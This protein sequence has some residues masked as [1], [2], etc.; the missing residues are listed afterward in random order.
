VRKVAGV[1]RKVIRTTPTTA[2]ENQMVRFPFKVFTICGITQKGYRIFFNEVLALWSL[3]HNMNRTPE[4]YFPRIAVITIAAILTV[5]TSC[6]NDP[7]PEALPQVN[8]ISPTSGPTNTPVIITGTNFSTIL[9]ENKVTFNGKDAVITVATSTQL[10]ATVPLLADTGPV[11]VTV[12]GK[13]VENHPVFTVGLAFPEV[14]NVSPVSGFTNIPVTITGTNFSTVL[15]DNKVTFNGKEAVVTLATATQLTATVPL[16]AETGPV[17]VT[18]KDK[19]ATTQPIFTVESPAP[20]VTKISPASGPRTTIVT[21][22][23][24][25]FSTV[26]SE[27]KVSFNG[28]MATVSGATVTQLTVTVPTAAGAGVVVVSTKGKTATNQPTFE[29]EWLVST[30]AGSDEGSDDGA[31]TS[32]KFRFPHGVVTD[33]NGN[34]YVADYEA[35]RIRK[36]TPDGV[37][38]TFAGSS[39]GAVNGTGTQAK[40]QGPRGIAVD[41]QGNLYVADTEN[42]SIRKITPDKVVSTL[43]GGN[44][45]GFINGNGLS[46]KFKSPRGVAIDSKGNIFVADTGNDCIRKITPDGEVSTLAGGGGAN[47]KDGIGVAAGFNSPESVTVD[48][49]DNVYVADLGNQSIR[50]ITPDQTVSTVAG[51]PGDDFVDGP[52][53]IAKFS[54]PAAV[55][56]D[57]KG[58][59]YVA[60]LGNHCIRKIT[61]D[62]VVTTFAGRKPKSDGSDNGTAAQAKFYLPRGI[63]VD[64]RGIIY[65]ADTG[66]VRIRKID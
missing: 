7:E 38:S 18:V 12:K 63:T 21:I 53:N 47:F 43:A 55:T 22:T 20:E 37:V 49:Q 65:V 40:F 5:L 13:S 50:K 29:Y 27:N 1:V 31:G 9:A 2:F 58:D 46:A 62:Q 33:P 61:P 44:G 14:S 17:V 42:N 16:L 64:S 15:L 4:F 25:N 36:I 66:N 32:A 6:S 26:T 48:V 60:D 8:N 11:I 10:T 34:V 52:G 39:Y 35:C 51:T 24:N 3:K 28:K 56:I 19:T 45:P 23:G 54:F 30:L 41:A 59:I 57:T